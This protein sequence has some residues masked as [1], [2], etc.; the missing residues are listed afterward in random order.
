MAEKEEG[1]LTHLRPGLTVMSRATSSY[2]AK[3]ICGGGRQF[4]CKRPPRDYSRSQVQRDL[5][6][7][8]LMLLA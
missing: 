2:V 4:D 1:E 7:F 3:L 5:S 6:L 8:N